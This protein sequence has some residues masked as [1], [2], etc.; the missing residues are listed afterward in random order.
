MSRTQFTTFADLEAAKAALSTLSAL[1]N[2]EQFNEQN[3]QILDFVDVGLNEASIAI[4]LAE[5]QLQR[6]GET[7]INLKLFSTPEL[8]FEGGL[9]K[10]EQRRQIVGLSQEI[11]FIK[12]EI[13]DLE[14]QLLLPLSPEKR[15]ETNTQLDGLRQRQTALQQGQIRKFSTELE[16]RPPYAASA[17]RRVGSGVSNTLALAAGQAAYQDVLRD[18]PQDLEGAEQARQDA[19]SAAK[20]PLVLEAGGVKSRLQQIGFDPITNVD[21]ATGQRIT[22]E[23]T[24]PLS[25]TEQLMFSTLPQV[26]RVRGESEPEGVVGKTVSKA[27]EMPFSPQ[28]DVLIETVPAYLLRLMGS[29]S[30]AGTA[31]ITEGL[32]YK[33]DAQ[34][35]PIDK[36]DLAYIA[37]NY[38]TNGEGLTYNGLPLLGI[39]VENVPERRRWAD[40]NSAFNLGTTAAAEGL[41]FLEVKQ[42][43]PAMNQ[44]D[45]AMSVFLDYSFGIGA[46]A[47][48]FLMP[49]DPLFLVSK[50][51]RAARGTLRF[52]R[53]TGPL[54]GL[55]VPLQAIKD[56]SFLFKWNDATKS[57]QTAF[58]WEPSEIKYLG[59]EIKL[60]EKSISL[61]TI[62]EYLEMASDISLFAAP[63]VISNVAAGRAYRYELN[64]LIDD[65]FQNRTS[66]QDVGG[67]YIQNVQNSAAGELASNLADLAV[68]RTFENAD[69]KF[70]TPW[71]TATNEDYAN[72]STL[73]RSDPDNPLR[74]AITTNEALIEDI[75]LM[76]QGNRTASMPTGKLYTGAFRNN[77]GRAA[78]RSENDSI[79][80]YVRQAYKENNFDNLPDDFFRRIAQEQDLVHEAVYH[81][82]RQLIKEQLANRLPV[83][84]MF[85]AGGT[86]TI[87]VALNNQLNRAKVKAL[88]SKVNTPVSVKPNAIRLGSNT[89]EQVEMLIDGIG[90]ENIRQSSFYKRLVDKVSRNEELTT[91]EYTVYQNMVEAAA[92]EN[93]ASKQTS[94]PVLMSE[95]SYS[96]AIEMRSNDIFLAR[97]RSQH[98][99]YYT[100]RFKYSPVYK[101]VIGKFLKKK[102]INDDRATLSTFEATKE[103]LA[104]T[105]KAF[106]DFKDSMNSIKTTE[107]EAL[108]A[109]LQTLMQQTSSGGEA[110]GIAM[111]EAAEITVRAEQ[112]ALTHKFMEL[113]KQYMTSMSK[114]KAEK[115]AAEFLINEQTSK[116]KLY[117]YLGIPSIPVVGNLRLSLRTE[118]RFNLIQQYFDK[119]FFDLKAADE[120]QGKFPSLIRTYAQGD[121]PI[122]PLMFQ[123]I[124]QEALKEETLRTTLE[125]AAVKQFKLFGDKRNAD[126]AVAETSLIYTLF[127][128]SQNKYKS[129]MERLLAEYPTMYQEL[130]VTSLRNMNSSY[131]AVR[132]ASKAREEVSKILPPEIAKFFDDTDPITMSAK[133]KDLKENLITALIE[134][135][136]KGL[137]LTTADAKVLSVKMISG[138][139]NFSIESK[140]GNQSFVNLLTDTQIATEFNK[141]SKLLDQIDDLQNKNTILQVLT[142]NT[143]GLN[144][145]YTGNMSS[146]SGIKSN[147]FI[148]Q[149]IVTTPIQLLEYELNQILKSYGIKIKQGTEK[150]QRL[151]DFVKN[152]KPW[153]DNVD[154]DGINFIMGSDVAD[155]IK[156]LKT[157]FQAEEFRKVLGQYR[158]SDINE[159]EAVFQALGRSHITGLLGGSIWPNSRYLLQN[160][161][162]MPLLMIT[163]LGASKTMQ[164]LTKYIWKD[165]KLN[166][167]G[168]DDSRIYLQTKT[169]QNITVE[170]YKKLL[171]QEEIATTFSASEFSVTSL[172]ELIRTIRSD[173]ALIK[174]IDDSLTYKGNVGAF[175][176]LG[177]YADPT[178]RTF[179]TMISHYT[180]MMFRRMI[181]VKHVI[182]N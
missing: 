100:S 58:T 88:V 89:D 5:S 7:D 39:D 156:I 38:I 175:R 86:R 130:G 164:A 3:A 30:S 161:L 54:G 145:A 42:N 113:R 115:A 66:M 182:L 162:T 172:S 53:N 63:E 127:L 139:I 46:L 137:F 163:E 52:L 50:P 151:T 119:Y 159:F 33:V 41:S 177:R 157:R 81:T 16:T 97:V 21:L 96:Q 93:V 59:S 14:N 180:D 123:K 22:P 101:G 69:D 140:F 117:K 109:R 77:L 76:R 155:S 1:R 18:N 87:S 106:L 13:N 168:L 74:I 178:K 79:R 118:I 153:L 124:Y 31:G 37:Q 95:R 150:N 48:D 15:A 83:D 84:L 120:L 129:E 45:S 166:A 78:A 181:M 71:A 94:T 35:N 91:Q 174:S 107:Y 12:D 40:A 142:A 27:L 57:Y 147:S 169:G 8:I 51:A 114:T 154:T 148:K 135:S 116:Y 32:T 104:I 49:L 6:N 173:S 20:K 170:Q 105:P 65:A 61:D 11:V 98:F 26:T 10:E 55:D 47:A 122:T 28:P 125:K 136:N 90:V 149:T 133:N 99:K 131:D 24:E 68:I 67:N 9:N 4:G 85:V 143:I 25:T 82:T 160:I 103:N 141:V 70:K 72:F 108:K 134:L 126:N 60:G 29:F 167:F 92:W 62:D 102:K 176:T 44:D 43:I 121:E 19:F 64:T 75:I 158:D 138:I 152:M 2:N 23:G 80:S 165:V 110:L 36:N 144:N 146:L 179:F 112:N 17:E 73:S 128:R 56:G 132:L 111:S 34:G 171:T